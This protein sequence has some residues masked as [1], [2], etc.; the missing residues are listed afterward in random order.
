MTWAYF[1]PIPVKMAFQDETVVSSQETVQDSEPE[2]EEEYTE[3]ELRLF[4][5]RMNQGWRML[6]SVIDMGAAVST[7][8]ALL[9]TPCSP[10]DSDRPLKWALSLLSDLSKRGGS[11]CQEAIYTASQFLV[12]Y[13]PRDVEEEFEEYDWAKLIPFGLFS[14]SPG[15]LTADYNQLAPVVKGL[16]NDCAHVEAVRP[17]LLEEA[18]TG[19]VYDRLVQIWGEALRSVK[20]AWGDALPVSFRKFTAYT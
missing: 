8:G 11:G 14:S 1:R 13:D 3:E 5:R 4:R 6:S 15:L 18:T 17:L 7:I 16:I 2:N 20:I 9:S 12:K 19:W 10:S